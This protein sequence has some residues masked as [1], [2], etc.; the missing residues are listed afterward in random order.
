M[1][2]ILH[3]GWQ[4]REE[5]VVP[6]I[7]RHMCRCDRPHLWDVELTVFSVMM[8]MMIMTMMMT[9]MLMTMIMLHTAGLVR[10]AAQGILLGRPVSHSIKEDWMKA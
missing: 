8:I 4:L 1:K 9:M 10:I 2:D 6:K 5:D 7:L 3:V